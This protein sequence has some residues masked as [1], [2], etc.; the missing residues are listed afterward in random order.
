MGNKSKSEEVVPDHLGQKTHIGIQTVEQVSS[1]V[2]S[3]A[4]SNEVG[5]PIAGLR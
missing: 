5:P 1:R 4:A 2:S 3:F